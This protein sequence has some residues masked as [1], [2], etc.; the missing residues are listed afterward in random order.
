MPSNALL[1]LRK[2]GLQQKRPRTC[3]F[4]TDDFNDTTKNISDKSKAKEVSLKHFHAESTEH[5]IDDSGLNQIMSYPKPRTRLN[6][7]TPEAFIFFFICPEIII[8]CLRNHCC[9]K[10]KKSCCWQSMDSSVR[11]RDRLKM[12]KNREK[13]ASEV[14]EAENNFW[15]WNRLQSQKRKEKFG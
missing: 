9:C 15:D 10:V 11:K 3:H 13:Q 2:Y 4:W 14:A 12:R 8:C 6:Q 1:L 7:L 5:N